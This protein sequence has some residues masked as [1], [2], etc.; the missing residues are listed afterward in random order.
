MWV[1]RAD[2][3]PACAARATMVREGTSSC[4]LDS[5]VRSASEPAAVR[6][7]EQVADLL[8]ELHALLSSG[9]PFHAALLAAVDA[10]DRLAEAV[11]VHHGIVRRIGA[12]AFLRH[13]EP[14]A[15]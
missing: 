9:A 2:T 10:V 13:P 15:R 1:E 7:A 12:G 6:H 4:D 11:A 8:V 3:E 5:G 14:E